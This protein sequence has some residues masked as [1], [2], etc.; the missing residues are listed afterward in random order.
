MAKVKLG[1]PRPRILSS[2]NTYAYAIFIHMIK[3]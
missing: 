1:N 2:R 3:Y